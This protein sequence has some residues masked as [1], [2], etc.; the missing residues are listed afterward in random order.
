MLSFDKQ[1][2]GLI[3]LAVMVLP[4]YV[5]AGDIAGA[6][7]M[8]PPE[9][10][11]DLS[12]LMNNNIINLGDEPDEYRTQ[13]LGF[14]IDISPRWGIVFDHSILTA[15][16]EN[17][18]LRHFAGRVDQVNLSLMYEL[19]HNQPDSNSVGIV[20]TGAGVRAYGDFG[21]DNMQNGFH[22]LIGNSIDDYPYVPTDTSMAIFW[23][24][25]D[26]QKL[27]PLAQNE[28]VNSRWRAGFWLDATGLVSSGQQWDAALSANVVVRNQ[29]MT[30]WLGVREDWRENYELDFVQE[31]TA[32]SESGTSLTFGLGVG[33]VLF[34]TVQ[35]LDDKFSYSRFIF[36]SVENE[37]S[38]TEYPVEA[39][40]TV[41][42]NILLPDVEAELQYKRAL[43][44]SSKLFG[45]PKTWLVL[46]M[47]YGEPTYDES[48]DAYHPVEQPW[49]IYT[50][51]SEVQQVAIGFEFEWRS[52]QTFQRVWPYLT[53]LA[54]HRSEQLKAN[55]GAYSSNVAGQESEI[56]SSA[57]IEAGVGVRFNLYT[58]RA[59]QFLIQTG[60]VGN[61]PLSSETVTFDQSRIELLQPNLTLN[62]GFSLNFGF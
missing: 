13:Q 50:V 57:V 56:V 33:P 29:D 12:F 18:V 15:G 41:A 61:Y 36:T 31:A 54:G 9:T 43:H 35:G 32:L 39:D 20:E 28:N 11:G 38:S 51:Y 19:Y 3:F 59:W 60:L 53:L 25:G 6:P 37:Y 42:L 48:F 23:L 30:I 46:G 40:N 21:G 26:Y 58:R 44:Y 27:Y 4:I 22:R 8:V 52:Q 17:P 45:Q 7:A 47:N 10:L 2:F 34:D 16:Q 5:R 24:K 55:S 62:L 14:Q 1:I 49:P